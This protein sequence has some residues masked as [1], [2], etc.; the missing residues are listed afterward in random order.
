MPV[1]DGSFYL[2]LDQ[3]V[4]EIARVEVG[5][6]VEVSATFDPGYR[7]GPADDM[8]KLL[9]DALSADPKV[10]GAWQSLAPSLQKE[11][12]RYLANLKSQDAKH[13]N[14]EKTLRVLAGERMRFLARSW[15]EPVP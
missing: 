8:P 6:I 12:L 9:Q 15:N 10:A 3:S 13:R 1:G 7:G 11:I 4:R 2:Y 14:V 5:E